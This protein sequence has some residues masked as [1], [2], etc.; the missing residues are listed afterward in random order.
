MERLANAPAAGQETAA[1]ILDIIRTHPEQHDQGSWQFRGTSEPGSEYCH[2]TRCVAGWAM[3]LHYGYVHAMV[4]DQIAREKLDLRWGDGTMLFH[5]TTE[6]QAV[7]ALEYL[8]KG[9]PID[10]DAVFERDIAK[11]DAARIATFTTT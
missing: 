4:V 3:H 11:R 6:D 2:T 9:D 8:A 7:H 1:A 10:W 5:Y